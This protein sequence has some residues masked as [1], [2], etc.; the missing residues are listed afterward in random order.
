LEALGRTQ[1]P[2]G[3]SQVVLEP[4][5]ATPQVATG[6]GHVE[7]SAEGGFLF[8]QRRKGTGECI[9]Y[10]GKETVGEEREDVKP[11]G[12]NCIVAIGETFVS[13][14]REEK[15]TRHKKKKGTLCGG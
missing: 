5:P 10:K 3:N 4:K 9:R 1:G 13:P 8:L 14:G 11:R 7:E 12:R 2:K 6:G 15:P